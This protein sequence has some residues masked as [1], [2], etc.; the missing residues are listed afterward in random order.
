MI[1]DPTT[2]PPSADTAKNT[3]T[4]NANVSR[5]RVSFCFAGDRSG[6][7]NWLWLRMFT[8]RPCRS[9]RRSGISSPSK[10]FLCEILEFDE[11]DRGRGLR[12]F[13]LRAGK[14]R[15]TRAYTPHMMNEGA[16]RTN[17]Q[18]SVN[19]KMSARE[20]VS[21]TNMRQI[22]K[23]DVRTVRIMQVS[24]SRL[25]RVS[26]VNIEEFHRGVVERRPGRRRSHC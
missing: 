26:V 17:V 16:Y 21:S 19:R 13:G 24:S 8:P 11:V 23:D 10:A 22:R 3:K 14:E 5:D 9:Y 20:L 2:A 7:R 25:D 4:N 18:Y 6:T 12:R 15:L 1:A